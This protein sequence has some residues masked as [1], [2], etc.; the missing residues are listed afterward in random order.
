MD[1]ECFSV[2]HSVH[3]YLLFLRCELSVIRRVNFS[4]QQMSRKEIN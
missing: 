2:G 1:L 4:V 3:V